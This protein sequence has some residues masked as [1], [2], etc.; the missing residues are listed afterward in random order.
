MELSSKDETQIKD[1]KFNLYKTSEFKYFV[2]DELLKGNNVEITTN[3]NLPSE[4][5]DKYFF[6]S[7]FFDLKDNNFNAAETK[8]KMKKNIFGNMD[9]DPRLIGVSSFKKN[10][11]TQVNKGIFTSCKKTDNC[12]PWSIKAEK[13]KHNK[14][15]KQLIYDNAILQIYD[16]PIVYFPKFFHP[17]PTVKRQSGILK[18]ILNESH[19]LGSSLKIPYYKVLSADKD[20]T[21]SPNIFEKDILMIENEFR[22]KTCLL[23]TSPS[24]RDNR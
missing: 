11:I 24:P 21:I 10:E 4:L 3:I 14:S 20:L 5:S 8:V 9:N 22:R 18:P 23:Y 13:I 16:V 1:N 17:D 15:R 19:I 6:S 12:P 2:N 7:G